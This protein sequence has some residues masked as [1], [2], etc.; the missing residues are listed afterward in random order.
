[1]KEI[2]DTVLKCMI[3]PKFPFKDV[4]SEMLLIPKIY[5]SEI[6]KEEKYCPEVKKKKKRKK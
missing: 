2:K 5:K 4:N 1:M 6:G 3:N